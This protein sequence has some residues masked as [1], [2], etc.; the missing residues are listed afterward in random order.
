MSGPEHI[1]GTWR[2]IGRGSGT[3]W[4]EGTPDARESTA[5]AGL[6]AT[7]PG[8]ALLLAREGRLVAETYGMGVTPDRLLQGGAMTTAILAPLA[9][10]AGS[11]GKA[12]LDVPLRQLLPD[13]EEDPRG[14]IT[15][16][17]LLWQV[18]GLE[19]PAWHPLDPFN[20]LARLMSGP[21]FARA[22]RRFKGKWPPGSHF[23]TSPANFQLAAL[24]LE[25]V[26][27]RPLAELVEQELWTPLGAGR[28]RVALDRL[29]GAMSAHC[30]LAAT[31]RDWL[32]LANAY[33]QGSATQLLPDGYLRNDVARATAVHP[34]YG[35]GVEIETLPDGTTLLWMGSG[36]R[37]MLAVPMKRIAVVWVAGRN[38]GRTERG[39]LLAALQLQ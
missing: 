23:E 9:G 16:R 29:D 14:D 35:L 22:A 37:W 6:M 32:R 4:P 36:N 5:L 28:A 31:A 1:P 26:T 10:R 11:G 13:Y 2:W 7:L 8:S 33:A 21:N 18:S 19:T 15:P 38:L 3:D 17:Q 27:G 25:S 12:F 34:G 24:A 20:P 39:M 30:C